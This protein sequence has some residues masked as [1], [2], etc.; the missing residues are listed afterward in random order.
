MYDTNL[1]T[2]PARD[3]FVHC[4][5]NLCSST[6][7]VDTNPLQ[8]NS[9]SVHNTFHKFKEAQSLYSLESRNCRMCG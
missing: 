8:W 6:T 2:L 3:T 5:H 4:N 7:M 1:S 9:K